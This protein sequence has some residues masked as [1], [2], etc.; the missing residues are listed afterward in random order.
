MEGAWDIL[1]DELVKGYRLL[2]VN[3]RNLRIFLTRILEVMQRSQSFKMKLDMV[4]ISHYNVATLAVISAVVITPVLSIGEI[5]A[6]FSGVIKS[7]T[8]VLTPIYIKALKDIIYIL[9][10]ALGL[11]GILKNLR[12]YGNTYF[13]LFMALV[14]M[15][16]LCSVSSNDLLVLVAGLRWILPVLTIVALYKY[17]DLQM[18]KRIAVA[19]ICVFVFGF[20]LQVIQLFFNVPWFGI[21]KF[22]LN[23]RNPGFY[24]MPS[25][26]A[27]FSL[28]TWYYTYHFC[29]NEHVRKCIV[30]LLCP[31]SVM[32]T[33]SATGLIVLAICFT[34]VAYSRIKQ[35]AIIFLASMFFLSLFA[36][37]LPGVT[38]RE[39]IYT[40][41]LQARI[42]RYSSVIGLNSAII[43][44]N[45]GSATNT[46]ILIGSWMGNSDDLAGF[47]ADSTIISI[48]HN[49]GLLSLIIFALFVLSSLRKTMM[50]YHFAII[51][52][53]FMLTIIVF[54]LFPANLLFMVNIAYHNRKIAA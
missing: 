11:V 53:L 37:Y 30:Y 49:T 51:Y 50:D 24:L 4:R 12:V 26:M 29:S 33:G 34:L 23:A 16:F 5:S 46:V 7:Q 1:S 36:L 8:I 14:T 27:M 3:S 18:Q 32:L 10:L 42:D 28:L 39:E 52:S 17:V 21:N 48:I 47:I 41:S 15:S 45:F 6:L 22:G 25:S 9:L 2:K 43:S 19:M 20:V 44:T 40:V 31:L 38:S 35:K 13:W 54:E